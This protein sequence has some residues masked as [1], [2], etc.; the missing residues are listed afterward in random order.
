MDTSYAIN[1]C[2]ESRSVDGAKSAVRH[3]QGTPW[4]KLCAFSHQPIKLIKPIK[5]PPQPVPLSHLYP[6][7]SCLLDATHDGH[8]APSPWSRPPNDT[9]GR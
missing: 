5:P 8:P 6:L 4:K 3:C 9:E 2:V 7:L 1:T